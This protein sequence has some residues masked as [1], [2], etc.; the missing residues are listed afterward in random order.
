MQVCLLCRSRTD[1]C[2]IS[3]LSRPSHQP[4][5]QII[6]AQIS[7]ISDKFC[8][9]L[10]IMWM[11]SDTPSRSGFVAK[12]NLGPLAHTQFRPIRVWWRKVRHLLQAPRR[13]SGATV[14]PKP[15][16]PDGFQGRT[17]KG[18]VREVVAGLWSVLSSCTVLWL[19]DGEVTGWC[20]RG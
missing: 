5:L 7:V 18:Q 4:L 10:N 3:A 12:A 9:L 16:T 14:A 8:L 17:S 1:P 13:E 19:L 20:H 15:W 6:T 2:G 11:K